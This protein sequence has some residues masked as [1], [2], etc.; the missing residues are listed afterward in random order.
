[1]ENEYFACFFCL[2]FEHFDWLETTLKKYDI[3]DYAIAYET[4]DS[5]G[6]P[7]PHF[8][9]LF[10]GTQN[11]YNNFSKVVADK[12]N[13]RRTGH[14]GKNKY[15]KVKEI[16]DLDKML[17]YTIKHK[18]FRT[19][20][21]EE[22]IEEALRNSFVKKKAQENCKT[23]METIDKLD[24]QQFW[25][26]TSFGNFNPK[27]LKEKIIDICVEMKIPLSEVRLK[28][29]FWYYLNNG[30]K[31]NGRRAEIMKYILLK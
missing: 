12:H 15:G 6:D 5:K 3:G 31:I 17:A 28:S 9:L 22:K 13:L 8:H 1:M 20:M 29:Y 2:E 4:E 19:N 11:I 25:L 14:G 21:S 18:R 16:R 23:I 10:S 30:T 27:L 24:N 26:W 7:K